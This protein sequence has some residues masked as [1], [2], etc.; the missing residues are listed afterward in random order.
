V[1]DGNN[2]GAAAEAGSAQ[3]KGCF[4]MRSLLFFYRIL[5]FYRRQGMGMGLR[6]LS[7]SILRISFPEFFFSHPP[8]FL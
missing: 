5:S 1:E 3:G 6:L 2:S 7:R 8:Q 4:R